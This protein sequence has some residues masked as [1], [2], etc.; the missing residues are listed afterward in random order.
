MRTF[1][2][3]RMRQ[4]HQLAA[5]AHE[6]TNAQDHLTARQHYSELLRQLTSLGLRS[7][8][9][10]WALA[11][12]N[13]YLGEHDMAL[14]EIRKALAMDPLS[15]TAQRSF[16]I[17][18]R[19]VREHLATVAV[20]DPSVP[21]LYALLQESGDLDVP[22]HLLMARHFAATGRVERAQQ[23]LAALALTAPAS[24]DVWLERARLARLQGDLTAAAG[25]EAEA[26]ARALPTVP[27]A[28]PFRTES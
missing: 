24:N 5:T 9:V 27:F 17:I 16:D 13:D 21:R 23:L 10:H 14:N 4:L 12:S 7:A 28:I 2:D 19:R 8:W 26:H 20:E 1:P 18:V 3:V 6:A 25:F 15:P 11:I 22:T